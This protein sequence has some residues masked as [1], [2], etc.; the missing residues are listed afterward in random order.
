[1]FLM[2]K[3]IKRSPKHSPKAVH[4]DPLALLVSEDLSTS[5]GFHSSAPATFASQSSLEKEY[6]PSDSSEQSFSSI[7]TAED[8]TQMPYYSSL[9]QLHQCTELPA[10]L[11]GELCLQASF[12]PQSPGLGGNCFVGGQIQSLALHTPG[13]NVQPLA[14][15][16]AWE[17]DCSLDK[18]VKRYWQQAEK[19]CLQR[20]FFIWSSQTQQLVKAQQ[21]CR[22]VQL[23][24]PFLSWHHWVVETKNRKAAASINHH[25]HCCQMVFNL[26]KKRLSQKGIGS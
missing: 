16:S 14:S 6:S 22:L 24:R 9:L 23:S 1:M 2:V 17:E 15:S 7:L 19:C 11:G 10:E 13:S 20:Y 8:V 26:W 4:K 18:E 12:S 5:S 21:Y 3:T 25:I